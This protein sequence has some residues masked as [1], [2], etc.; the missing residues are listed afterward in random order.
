MLAI[1]AM[2]DARAPRPSR[3]STAREEQAWVRIVECEA[4]SRYPLEV[5]GLSGGTLRG[6]CARS[7]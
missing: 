2:G 5:C 6:H 3:V 7:G 1:A 4:L